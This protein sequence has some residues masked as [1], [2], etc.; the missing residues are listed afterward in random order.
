VTDRVRAVE[1]AMRRLQIQE[2]NV[3]VAQTSFDFAVRRFDRGELTTTELA[4][5]QD[6]L[7]QTRINYLNAWI[8]FEMAKA[9]LKEITLWDWETNQPA[10]RRTTPPEPF[11]W[12]RNGS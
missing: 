12:R 10:V 6:Q 7:S 3:Q 1:T 8:S 2:E 9:D 11:G 4:R 5:A